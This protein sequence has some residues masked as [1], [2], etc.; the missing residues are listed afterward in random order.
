MI[1]LYIFF[2]HLDFFLTKCCEN[3]GSVAAKAHV[4]FTWR[5]WEK[6]VSGSSSLFDKHDMHIISQFFLVYKSKSSLFFERLR[7][8]GCDSLLCL[9]LAAISP[10]LKSGTAWITTTATRRW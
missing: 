7:F 4:V 8:L 1:F 5:V 9:P 6:E 3:L 10:L 2:N